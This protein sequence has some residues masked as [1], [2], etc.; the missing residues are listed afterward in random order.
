M[1]SPIDLHNLATKELES[2]GPAEVSQLIAEAAEL[3]HSFAINASQPALD[4]MIAA[5]AEE[6]EPQSPSQAWSLAREATA[7]TKILDEE[8]TRFLAL[9]DQN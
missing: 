2:F 6:I 9:R 1:A 8:V 3:V 7:Q 4:A 5:A